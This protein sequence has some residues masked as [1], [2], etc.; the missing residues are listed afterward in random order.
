VDDDA[1]TRTSSRW[2]FQRAG[3]SFREAASGSE[4]L[5][6][7][8]DL[9]D[10]VILD[11]NL[12]DLDG[13]EVCRRIKAKACTQGIPVLHLSAVYVTPADRAHGLDGGADAYLTKPVEPDELIA[14]VNALLRVR[15]AEERARLEARHWQATF[16]AISDGVCLLDLEGRVLRCNQAMTRV[17]GLPAGELAGCDHR[18]LTPAPPGLHAG[19]LPFELLLKS[20]RREI[21]ELDLGERWFQ[22]SADPLFREDGTL[23]GAVY[24]LADVTA[25]K[26]LEQQLAQAQKMEAVGHLAGGIAHDFN[27]LL[28]IIT[29]N[30]ELALGDLPPDHPTRAPLRAAEEAA[31]RAAELIRQLLGY[32]RR[33][34]LRLGPADLNECIQETVGLLRR[35][36]DSRVTVEVHDT[37]GLWPVR[38]DLVQM[39]QVLRNLCLNACDAMAEGGCLT[40]ET[41]NVMVGGSNQCQEARPGRFVRLSVSDTGHGIAPETLPFIFDPFF[42]TKPFGQGT[43]L[44]LSVAY[45]VVKQHRGWIEC[46]SDVGRGTRF[47]I[48][49]PAIEE[50]DLPAA[51]EPAAAG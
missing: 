24:L 43:G 10:V 22:A 30:V 49:L 25:R 16:D 33:A 9:P 1:D 46:R 38:A 14:H 15:R 3:F 44:G 47:D 51:P 5:R 21:A 45:G 28:A 36:I 32:A 23:G 6:L 26:R 11:V 18:T 35:T 17:T 37:P 13:F 27:N 20:L 42:T 12:P 40:L 29:G 8:E 7:A 19:P 48:H 4:A 41:A 39:G 50:A 34:T 31:W 2:I